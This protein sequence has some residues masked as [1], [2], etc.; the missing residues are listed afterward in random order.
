MKEQKIN[1][2]RVISTWPKS[3]VPG[4]EMVRSRD[5]VVLASTTQVQTRDGQDNMLPIPTTPRA[6]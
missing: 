5:Q 2:E 1:F 4:T 6:M 3:T